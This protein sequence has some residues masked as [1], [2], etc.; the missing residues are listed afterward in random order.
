[1]LFDPCSVF[2]CALEK[3][4]PGNKNKMF[5]QKKEPVEQ[6]KNVESEMERDA[7]SVEVNVREEG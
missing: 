7:R 3:L 5:I 2:S 6:K 4:A 1:M